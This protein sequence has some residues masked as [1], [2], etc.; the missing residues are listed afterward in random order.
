VTNNTQK[1]E[2]YNS[3]V[4]NGKNVE[5]VEVPSGIYICTITP[6]FDGV[7]KYNEGKKNIFITKN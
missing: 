7:E 3:W 1:A 4:W 6:L 2:R 5:Q